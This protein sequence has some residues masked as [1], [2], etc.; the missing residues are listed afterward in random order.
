MSQVITFFLFGNKKTSI[1]SNGSHICDMQYLYERPPP[2][3]F[4]PHG[5]VLSISDGVSVLSKLAEYIKCLCI[6]MAHCNA[7]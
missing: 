5:G 4:L 1:K 2:P 7:I 6:L 3:G